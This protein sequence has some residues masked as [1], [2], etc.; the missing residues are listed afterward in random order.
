M[1]VLEENFASISRAK[2]EAKQETSMKQVARC[3][4][5]DP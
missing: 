1:N 4:Y 5:F 3:A 2:K